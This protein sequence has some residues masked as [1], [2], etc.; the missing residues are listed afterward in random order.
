ME[1]FRNE[2]LWLYKTGGMSKRWFGR[3]H[4][5]ILFYS[6]GKDYIFNPQKEESYLSH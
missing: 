4:D 5:N 6:R 1:K 2:V 3:K